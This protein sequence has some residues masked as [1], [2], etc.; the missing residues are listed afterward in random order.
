MH[1]PTRLLL[2]GW[3]ERTKLYPEISKSSSL[4]KVLE[5]R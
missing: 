2:E 4:G 5:S 1:T 3:S